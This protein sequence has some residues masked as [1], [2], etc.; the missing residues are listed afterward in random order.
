[1]TPIDLKRLKS[2]FVVAVLHSFD[3]LLPLAGGVG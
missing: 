3:F 1:M 2:S